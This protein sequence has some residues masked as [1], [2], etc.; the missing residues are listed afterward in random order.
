MSADEF[1]NLLEA[2]GYEYQ[3]GDVFEKKG[4]EYTHRFKVEEPKALYC[5]VEPD[6]NM[7]VN[8][9]SFHPD[10]LQWVEEILTAYL[11]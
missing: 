5:A 10:Q 8:L 11:T 6:F 9:D 7:A 4:S 2:N 3:V 1:V